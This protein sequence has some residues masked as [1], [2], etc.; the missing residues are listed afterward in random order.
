MQHNADSLKHSPGSMQHSPGSLKHS[1]GSMQHNHGSMQHTSGQLSLGEDSA[2]EI[3]YNMDSEI[4]GGK[5][6]IEA[7]IQA[8]H[9]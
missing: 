1:P 9:V 2:C 7:I 8:V 6:Q 3:W 5:F 4:K